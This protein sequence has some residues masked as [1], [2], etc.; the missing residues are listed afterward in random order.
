MT[1][2]QKPRASGSGREAG[3]EEVRALAGR[4]AEQI[5]ALGP[6]GLAAFKLAIASFGAERVADRIVDRFDDSL[7]AHPLLSGPSS[8]PVLHGEILPPR[9]KRSRAVGHPIAG[10]GL[11]TDVQVKAAGPGIHKIADATGLMLKVG[12]KGEGSYVWRYRFGGRRREIG[13]GSRKD[14]K[15]ADALKRVGEQR[16][17]RDQGVDPI[18]KRRQVREKIAAEARA[19]KPVMFCDMTEQFLDEHASNWKRSDART[20]WLSPVIAYAY[21]LI[22]QKGVDVIEVADVRAVIAATKAAGFKKVGDKVRSQIEQVL[23]FAISLGHRSADKLNPASGKLHPRPKKKI[24]P[25]HFRAPD[26]DDA[27]A[28]FRELR[29]RLMAHTAFAAW[30]LMIL[31]A[32]RPNEALGG[33]WD[34]IDLVKRLWTIPGDE[35]MKGG[36]MKW[37]RMKNGR[38]HIVPLSDAALEVLNR[39]ARVRTGNAIFPGRGGSP[40]SYTSFFEAPSKAGIDAANPHGWRSTFKDF[41]GDIAEDVSWETAEAALAHSLTALEASYRHRTAVE[42][43]RKVMTDYAAWLNGDSGARVV[44]LDERRKA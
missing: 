14:V 15:L 29:A 41:C 12:D 24:N 4:Y 30:C 5:R 23:S 10:R 2:R 19:A 8:S 21:P 6:A 36:R 7:A 37:G 1:R 42:K 33:Q 28:I 39:Q 18:D 13:L 31:C 43:R 16:V 38:K 17:L 44:S 25:V 32:L 9:A 22:K 20:A 40:I 27:P 26:F 3:E 11:T 35:E 34:E